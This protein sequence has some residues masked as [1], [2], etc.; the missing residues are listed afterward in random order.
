[1]ERSRKGSRKDGE[2]EGRSRKR[3][4]GGELLFYISAAKTVPRK[5]EGNV[6]RRNANKGRT[7][8]GPR[9]GTIP[10]KERKGGETQ[11]VAGNDLPLTEVWELSHEG[12]NLQKFVEKERQRGESRYRK[13]CFWGGGFVFEMEGDAEEDNK[14][15]QN[16]RE[17]K[18]RC[19]KGRGGGILDTIFYRKYGKKTREKGS[20]ETPAIRKK[21]GLAL[22]CRVSKSPFTG[23]KLPRGLHA[24]ER[25]A[26]GKVV[27][28]R[29]FERESCRREGT[30]KTVL[31]WRTCKRPIAKGGGEVADE[32]E[33]GTR[34]I[35]GR[36][37]VPAPV[38]HKVPPFCA[39]ASECDKPK[40]TRKRIE[41]HSGKKEKRGGMLAD[42]GPS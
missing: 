19:Q 33:E 21:A 8:V 13:G 12:R 39:A 18:G 42:F 22:G 37:R 34:R 40:K 1:L 6:K 28:R 3:A 29:T 14:S 38:G 31:G 35:A 36:K 26:S 2:K 17:R 41:W 7:V 16:D 32:R 24:A 10:R 23:G 27:D 5:R 9:A 30:Q 20:I 15:P 11:P 25:L 4:T